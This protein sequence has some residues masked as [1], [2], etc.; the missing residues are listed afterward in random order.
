MAL[1]TLI[2]YAYASTILQGDLKASLEDAKAVG[3]T[4]RLVELEQFRGETESNAGSIY[5]ERRD[6]DEVL[7]DAI[8]QA[9]PH[10]EIDDLPED[11]LDFKSFDTYVPTV[12]KDTQRDLRL[13]LIRLGGTAPAGASEDKLAELIAAQEDSQA[14]ARV[15]VLPTPASQGSVIPGGPVVQKAGTEKLVEV[16]AVGTTDAALEEAGKT[17]DG[18]GD[19]SGEG[20]APKGGEGDSGQ[21]DQSGGAPVNA[22]YEAIKARPLSALTTAQLTTVGSAEGVDLSEAGTNADRVKLIQ[23]KRDTAA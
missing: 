15:P 6:G 3:Q 1:K 22:D 13:R 14:A 8:A 5:V 20:D 2:I 16:K 4:A 19:Q 23:A 11:G 9:Y 21:G 12:A 18:A 10:L 7:I 17:V